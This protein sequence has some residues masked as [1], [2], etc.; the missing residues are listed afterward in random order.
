MSHTRSLRAAVPARAARLA[1]FAALCAPLLLAGCYVVPVAPAAE[2]VYRPVYPKPYY[3]PRPY[4]R[5]YGPYGFGGGAAAEAG[6]A[7]RSGAERGWDVAADGVA[8][9]YEGAA[10][11]AVTF[12]EAERP[13]R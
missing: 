3:Y 5:G 2:P 1:L 9:A 10:G 4:Y 11:R 6:F 13:A 12:A 8:V 7:H